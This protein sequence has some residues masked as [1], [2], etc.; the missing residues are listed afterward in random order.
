MNFEDVESLRRRAAFPNN[1]ACRPPAT[2]YVSL[3][4]E[5]KRTT[6]ISRSDRLANGAL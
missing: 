2:L 6:A 1:T 3:R 5:L 4:G